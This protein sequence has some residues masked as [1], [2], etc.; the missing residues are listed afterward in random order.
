MYKLVT[1]KTMLNG[2]GKILTVINLSMLIYNALENKWLEL[3]SRRLFVLFS[4]IFRYLSS[5]VFISWSFFFCLYTPFSQNSIP[6][7]DLHPECT[8]MTL[9]FISPVL[10]SSWVLDLLIL[11]PTWFSHL[12]ISDDNLKYPLISPPHKRENKAK[13]TNNPFLHLVYPFL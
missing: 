10:N 7:Q 12:D 8:L 2:I 5:P 13:Q 1:S 11:Q 3:L 9:K 6:S 4:L